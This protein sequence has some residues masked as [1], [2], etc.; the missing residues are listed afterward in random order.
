MGS[1]AIS[2]A[3]EVDIQVLL[4]LQLPEADAAE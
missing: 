1:Q 2:H 3:A 4:N